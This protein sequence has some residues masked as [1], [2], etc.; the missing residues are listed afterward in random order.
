MLI[1]L[2][3]LAITTLAPPPYEKK[4]LTARWMA[5]TINWG[6]L[7]TTSTRDEGTHAG[8]AFG[9]PY[10]F[11]SVKG[12]PYFYASGMDSSMI[13]LN[14]DADSNSSG[15]RASFAISEAS[16][17]TQAECK[18][19]SGSYGD[20]ENPP[21]ARLV[22]S[23]VMSKVPAG[24]AEEKIAKAALIATHPSFATLPASH[25]FFT[26]K[27]DLDGIWLIDFYGG[28][29]II[30][31]KDYFAANVSSAAVASLRARANGQSVA[32]PPADAATEWRMGPPPGPSDAAYCPV[33]GAPINITASTPSVTF[34]HGQ[35]LY[36]SSAQAA[37][38]YRASP[39]E[40]WL[41]PTDTPLPGPD[42]MRGLPD[43]RGRTLQCPRSGESLHVDMKT[44]RVDHK[45][46]QA[47]YFCCH[48]CITAFWRDPQSLLAPVVE[49]A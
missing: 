1:N 42:G 4:A 25:K 40:H 28:A 43:L 39:R 10:S 47:V 26:A 16:L 7:S 46:G 19:A 23:G 13:D 29:A 44:P 17:G 20:P 18:I 31:P 33:S 15:G 12:Q 27:M 5:Q 9:N 8:D 34:V 22:L 41:T 14:L 21:C 3:L 35:K 36:F 24:S 49:H 30:E 45:H 6:V 11:A 2:S 32:A 48:G 38:Q 37:A